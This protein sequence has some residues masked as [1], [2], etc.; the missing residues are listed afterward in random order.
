MHSIRHGAVAIAALALAAAVPATLAA[1]SGEAL[2]QKLGVSTPVPNPTFPADK[3]VEYKVLWDV[4][5]AAATPSDITP[6]MARP[7]NFLVMADA[8]GLD[9]KRV[10]LAL[11]IHGAAITSVLANEQYKTATG[12][13]NPNIALMQAMA[14]AGVQIIACGQAMAGRKISREQ[15]LPFVKVATSATMARATLHA[16]GYATFTP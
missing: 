8:N 2:I 3:T 5:G 13:D 14:D 12:V 1:Q 11:I 4:T 10:H 7:A 16:Q 15:L 6:G 9:R